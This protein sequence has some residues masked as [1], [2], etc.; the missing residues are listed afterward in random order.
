MFLPG[1]KSQRAE[2]WIKL[3]YTQPGVWGGS[4][5]ISVLVPWRTDRLHCKL[6]I[7]PLYC[8][9][10]LP[11]LKLKPDLCIMTLP[12]V[13]RPLGGNTA[14]E[15]V[16]SRFLLIYSSAT[17]L[18]Y[19][20]KLLQSKDRPLTDCLF[21]CYQQSVLGWSKYRK[22]VVQPP[23]HVEHLDCVCHYGLI[24]VR[25]LNCVTAGPLR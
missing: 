17:Q 22:P 8:Q 11:G 4:T 20:K 1:H 6:K 19:K 16:S 12:W 10:F 7:T 14:G 21:V 18:V 23:Q 13:V 9:C 25:Y 3:F 15:T 2:V 24:T 5:S